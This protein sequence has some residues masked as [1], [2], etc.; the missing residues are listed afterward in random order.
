MRANGRDEERK[1]EIDQKI[2]GYKIAE[3][4]NVASH[5]LARQFFV[6]SIPLFGAY[7]LS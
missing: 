6:F 1:T 3:I 7:P 5:N 2:E 4:L